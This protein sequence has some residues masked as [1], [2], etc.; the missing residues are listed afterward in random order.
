MQHNALGVARAEISVA[1]VK[2]KEQVENAGTSHGE[3]RTRLG[4]RLRS[5]QL[6][7]EMKT[8]SA[9][10]R[11][12]TIQTR[13]RLSS[14]GR[15]V[16]VETSDRQVRTTAPRRGRQE[17]HRPFWLSIDQRKMGTD[18][19]VSWHAVESQRRTDVHGD[20]PTGLLSLDP[21]HRR[22]PRPYLDASSSRHKRASTPPRA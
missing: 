9:G 1:P 15:A 21:S 14:T 10:T 7:I 6:R 22:S 2:E 13:I 4:A 18:S 8:L 11:G 20:R 3:A 16:L 12:C 5:I 19:A 17:K